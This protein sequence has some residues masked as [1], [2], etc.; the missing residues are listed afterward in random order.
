MRTY[1]YQVD[2]RGRVFLD[3]IAKRTE[4]TAIRDRTFLN[5]FFQRLRN[6]REEDDLQINHVNSSVIDKNL[7]RWVSRCGNELNFIRSDDEQT[8]IVFKDLILDNNNPPQLIFGGDLLEWF[9]PSRIVSH[10]ST[11]R[12]YYE[13]IVSN[14]NENSNII[15]PKLGLIH[16]HLALEFSEKYF[17]WHNSGN[18]LYFCFQNEKYL[19]KFID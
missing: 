8:P 11:N 18:I 13:R 16:P 4:A 14:E 1:L 3:D 9:D 15:K 5:R 6:R 19:C 7:F 12:I 17:Q 10:K 2:L